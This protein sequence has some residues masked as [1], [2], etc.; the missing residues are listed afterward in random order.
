MAESLAGFP[1]WVLE[2]DKDCNALD[3]VARFLG[4]LPGEGLTDLFIFS[5]GWNNDHATAL[6]LYARFFGAMRQ[7]LDNPSVTVRPAARIGVAGV[8]WPSILFPGDTVPP[9]SDGGAS[10]FSPG[11]EPSLESEL[12]KAFCRSDQQETLQELIELLNNRTPSNES[13]L[14]FRDKLKQL[15][16]PAQLPSTQDD[17]EAV[18]KVDDDSWLELL[19]KTTE[20]P[21]ETDSDGGAASLGGVFDKLWDGAK[22]LLRVATYWEMKNRAGLVGKNGLGPLLGKVNGGSPELRIHLLGHSFGARLVSYSL[23]GLPDGLIGPQSPIKMLLLLQ[24]AFSH[25]AFAAK[26]PFDAGR[27]GDLIGMAKRVDGPLLATYSRKDTAVGVSYPPASFLAGAD[28]SDAGDVMYRWEGMGC[29]GA[30]AV[31]AKGEVL[32]DVFTK[33]PFAT[34]EWLNLDGNDVIVAGGPPSGAH[35]DIVHPETAWAALAAARIVS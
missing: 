24:G 15:V 34:G 17:L 12:S 5:H 27:S 2:F 14:L 19:S 3:S 31:D 30:Q 13:L 7:I 35:S 32:G 6:D 8:L 26:L 33:Y 23:Q 29:D 21:A 16:T 28:A 9:A 11:Q 1:F 25:F 22:G 10:S 18:T 4:E 20:V